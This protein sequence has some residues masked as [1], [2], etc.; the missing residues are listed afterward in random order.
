MSVIA[1]TATVGR[2]PTRISAFHNALHSAKASQYNLIRMSSIIP[3]SWT[4]ESA[5]ALTE[6]G[7]PGDK[8]YCVYAAAYATAGGT[9][10]AVLAWAAPTDERHGLFAEACRGTSAEAEDEALATLNAMCKT[11]EFESPEYGMLAADTAALDAP[12]AC[13]L[14]L[15]AYGFETWSRVTPPFR[16]TALF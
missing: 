4:V 2:G 15:A 6:A 8:L 7:G 16:P 12:H 9:C 1:C 14:V 3:P 13:A 11:S 5:T 10:A